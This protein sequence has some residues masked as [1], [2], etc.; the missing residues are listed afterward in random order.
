VIGIVA[1]E[2]ISSEVA[3]PAYDNLSQI[4]GNFGNATQ[5]QCEA[6]S[7]KTCACQGLDEGYGGASF[8]FGCSWSMYFDGCKYGKGGLNRDTKKFR[9]TK[10]APNLKDSEIEET[11]QH[12][13]TS[14]GFKI[15]IRLRPFLKNIFLEK[16]YFSRNSRE[17]NQKSKYFWYF[18]C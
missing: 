2:G 12:I 3:D 6:N 16:N 9:L 10:D 15:Q 4:L 14:D 13:G 7:K 11:L 8:S 17:K 5:R 1:W 18:D